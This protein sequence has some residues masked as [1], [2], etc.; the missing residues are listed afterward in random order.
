FRIDYVAYLQRQREYIAI[1]HRLLGE[2]IKS[3]TA[4]DKAGREQERRGKLRGIAVGRALLVG[5]RLPQPVDRALGHLADQFLDLARFDAS[6][7]EPLGAIDVGMRHGPAWIWLECQS[8]RYPTCAKV[9]DK[10]IIVALRG[11]RETMKEP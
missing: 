9:A 4:T 3:D 1:A 5:K 10:G 2:S 11:V 7:G 8:L 6:C